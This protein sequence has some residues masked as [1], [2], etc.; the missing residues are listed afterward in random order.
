MLLAVMWAEHHDALLADMYQYYHIDIR[1]LD[2]GDPDLE[3]LCVLASQLP[4]GA[5]IWEAMEKDAWSIESCILNDISYSLKMWLYSMTPESR[6]GINKPTPI[7]PIFNKPDPEGNVF[8]DIKQLPTEYFAA[9]AQQAVA[10]TT[11]EEVV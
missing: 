10:P 2:H 9:L 3:L 11:P 5:R 7:L 1:G 4:R 8:A 6:H